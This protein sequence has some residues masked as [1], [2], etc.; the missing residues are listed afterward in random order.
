M[1]GRQVALLRGINVGRAK[2]VAMADLRGLVEA[3]GCREVKTLLNS[4]NVV[5]TSPRLGPAEVGARIEKGLVARTGVSARVTVLTGAELDAVVAGNP[6]GKTASDPSRFL[7]AVL[8][9]PKDRAK[10]LPLSRQ[11]WGGDVLAV[12]KRVAYLWC[13]GG[14]LGSRLLEEL[15]R[16]LGDGVTTRNWTTVTK[17]QALAG[18]GAER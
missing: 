1:P 6:L 13:A 16:A 14:I 11:D 2:R 9:D 10:L 5:F 18:Q 12:G 7:V 8:R 15:G 3:I 4:G 17:L